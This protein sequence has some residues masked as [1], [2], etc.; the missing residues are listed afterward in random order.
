LPVYEYEHIE[1]ACK[2]KGRVFE[3][4][5][6]ISEPALERCP[7][8]GQSVRRLISLPNIS[9][10]ISDSRYREMGFTKLVRRDDGVYENVTA[11]DSESRYFERDKPETMPDLKRR[12][13]D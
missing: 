12:I 6:S 8:C 5:Q 4:E 1:E 13:Q 11:L 2:E 3:V 10:P 9:T 7:S